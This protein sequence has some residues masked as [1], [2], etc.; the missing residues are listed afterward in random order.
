ME[1][2]NFLK[3]LIDLHHTYNNRLQSFS[4]RFTR[5]FNFISQP[6][7][8]STPVVKT[9]KKKSDE[10]TARRRLS[11]NSITKPSFLPSYPT[12]SIILA[13]RQRATQDGI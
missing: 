11:K 12:R 2:F 9:K 5:Y 8:L 10:F 7:S 1:K 4:Q 3:L 13:N 6:A